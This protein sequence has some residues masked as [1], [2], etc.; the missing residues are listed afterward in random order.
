MSTSQSII[1]NQPVRH[2]DVQFLPGVPVG[3]EDPDAVPYFTGTGW[4]EASAETPV[5]IYPKSVID[6]DPA[7][8]FAHGP[9]KG[10]R[11]LEG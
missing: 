7:T 2:G 6:I 10:Q 1:F 11:V 4:A 9:K 5:H 3:F 8:I